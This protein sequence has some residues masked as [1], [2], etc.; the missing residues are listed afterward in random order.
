MSEDKA[1]LLESANRIQLELAAG[2]LREAGIPFVIEGPD[3]DM[4]EL[5]RAAHNMIRGQNLYVPRSARARA[6][7]ILDEAWSEEADGFD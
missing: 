5:G 6:A 1:L 4:A 2:L 3:F 7:A